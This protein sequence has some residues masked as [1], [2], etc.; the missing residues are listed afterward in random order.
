MSKYE[1]QS[2]CISCGMQIAR[3]HDDYK[4]DSCTPIIFRENVRGLIKADELKVNY[5]ELAQH[6]K[7]EGKDIVCLILT[8][9]SA[10]AIYE[11]GDSCGYIHGGKNEVLTPALVELVEKHWMIGKCV[12]PTTEIYGPFVPQSKGIHRIKKTR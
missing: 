5:S 7:A 9:N 6:M 12:K 11:N 8:C 4:S 2:K 10:A 3:D 1:E